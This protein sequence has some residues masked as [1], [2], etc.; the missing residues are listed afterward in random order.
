LAGAS[1]KTE[2]ILDKKAHRVSTKDFGDWWFMLM[3]LGSIFQLVVGGTGTGCIDP[4]S[5]RPE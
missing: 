5:Q 4:Y 2:T 3:Q 1:G